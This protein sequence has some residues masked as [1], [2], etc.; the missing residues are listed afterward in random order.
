MYS[1]KNVFI[2]KSQSRTN[3]QS[4]TSRGFESFQIGTDSC[5]RGGIEPCDTEYEWSFQADVS[6]D[7]F[8]GIIPK[9]S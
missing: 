5:T 1:G 3:A 9:V 6:F 4:I 8:I 2:L 7:S